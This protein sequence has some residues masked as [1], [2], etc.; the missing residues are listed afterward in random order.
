MKTIIIGNDPFLSKQIKKIQFESDDFPK[1]QLFNSNDVICGNPSSNMAIAFV[2][3]WKEDMPPKQVMDFFSRISVYAALT[4][5]WRTTNGGKYVCA[6]ILANPNINKLLVIAFS[7]KDNGHLLVHSLESLW[8][9][10]VNER[11]IIQNCKAPNPKFEQV[12]L[13]ALE[14]LT[15]QADLLIM[16]IATELAEIEAVVKAL[17]QEPEHAVD[18]REFKGLEFIS[19]IVKNNLLYDCG[20]RYEEPLY[21]DLVSSAKNVRY[22]EKNLNESIGQS[23]QAQNLADA[24][25]QVAGFVFKNGTCIIDQRKIVTLECRSLS[26]SILEPLEKLPEGFSSEYLNAYCD[27]FMNGKGEKLDEFAYTYHERIFKRW[28]NQVEKAIKKIQEDHSTRRMVISLWS[29]DEDILNPSAPCLDLIWIVVRNNKLEM[30]VLFR[31]HHLATM[32]TEGKLMSGEGAFVPN[33]YALAHLQEYIA[34]NIN[35][36]R[37]PFVVTDLSGHVYVS[38]DSKEG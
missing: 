19:K 32:T 31:S 8:K 12:P 33:V 38:N 10:G 17:M 5:F 13:Y 20:A 25:E 21:I 15:Q 35:I 36:P 4:G 14:R 18:M 16:S 11:G 22:E 30:H 29:P 28:G 2:Y 24:L 3:T 27:E 26:I 6:N 7:N 23:V 9:Y 34:K 37:G 1:V